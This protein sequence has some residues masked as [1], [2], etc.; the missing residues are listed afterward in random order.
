M[1][2]KKGRKVSELS[3]ALLQGT[4]KPHP[5]DAILV[6]EDGFVLRGNACGAPGEVVG[7][8]CFN[9][10]VEGYLEIITDPSYAGQIVVL[11]YP[12]V[13]AYGVC[14]DD[15]QS[16]TPALRGLVVRDMISTPSSWRSTQALP[17]YLKSQGVVALENVDTRALVRHIRD[18]GAQQAILSTECFDIEV[19]RARLGA[20]PRLVGQNLAATVAAT[21]VKTRGVDTLRSGHDFAV[22]AAH[23][24]KHMVVAYDCGVKDSILNGLIRQGCEVIVVPWDTPAEEVLALN[25]DGV[26]LSNGPG[27]PD[28][29]DTTYQ[30][31]EKL[32]GAVPVFGICLGHQMISKASGA[33]I[34]KLPFGHHGGNHPVK[35]LLSNTVEI[36]AQNHGFNLDFTTLGPLI[37]T[38]SGGYADHEQDL[39]VWVQRKVAPVVHNERFG[40]IQLTHVN[41]ND[42][43]AEGIAFLDIPAFSVQY[44]PESTPG[45]TD[46]HYLFEAF[47]RLMDH[48][49][50]YLTSGG[51]ASSLACWHF[52]A[53][54]KSADES[55]VCNA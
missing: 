24:K 46:S 8:V 51:V 19:L 52:G 34:I 16:E 10:S 38:E 2:E 18:F 17:E 5:Q 14:E 35:N 4:S 36:T 26:F 44:H 6:L 15:Y 29:V 30:Q 39:R 50:N 31:V 33:D 42:G 7:E 54:Q 41:L 11:T 21:E 27:D 37:A 23:P 48:E 12:Q 28:A 1:H 43:T 25:P 20:A 55:E 40:R 53:S 22:P 32:L 49:E 47:S 3:A 9:T 13:G 45:P